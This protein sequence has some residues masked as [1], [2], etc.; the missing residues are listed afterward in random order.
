MHPKKAWLGRALLA[1]SVT[2]C[3]SATT[4]VSVTKPSLG[5]V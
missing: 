1:V 5:V 3:G 2:A 4:V